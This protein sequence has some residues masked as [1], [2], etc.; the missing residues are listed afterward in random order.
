MRKGMLE[1]S[2][3]DKLLLESEELFAALGIEVTDEQ[4][5]TN[6]R[7]K[8]RPQAGKVCGEPRKISGARQSLPRGAFRGSPRKRTE[9]KSREIRREPREISRLVAGKL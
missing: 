1:R 8:E 7:G 9:A 5:E 3:K 6:A 2:L 4:A